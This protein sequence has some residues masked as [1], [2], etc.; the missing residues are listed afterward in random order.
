[1]K[2][3]ILIRENREVTYKI[4][5][6]ST[7]PIFALT[8]AIMNACTSGP[9]VVQEPEAVVE[10]VPG[11]WGE[12]RD[13]FAK[14]ALEAHG[15]AI[16]QLE[17]KD[18]K[19]WCKN[20]DNVNRVNFYANL[21]SALAKFESNYKSATTYGEDMRDAK[22][23]QVI[24]RGLLQISQES[25]NSYGCNIKDAK[26]LHDDETNIRCGV[27]IWNKNM[28]RDR[29]I[30]GGKIGAWLGGASYHSPFRKDNRIASMKA[31]LKPLCE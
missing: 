1:M 17:P 13:N 3:P 27:L 21:L 5:F 22:G 9:T 30:N 6:L 16:L 8:F 24:S 20:W 19:E 29:R 14:E 10:W 28:V 7:I 4:L 23:K 15:Q 11:A 2:N 31:A 18:A 26:E 12:A 25:A